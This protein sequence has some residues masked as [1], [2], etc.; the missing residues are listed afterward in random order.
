[1]LAALDI[2]D[3]DGRRPGR[4]ELLKCFRMLPHVVLNGDEV[5]RNKP[6]YFGIGV[7]HGTHLLAAAS[8]R[9]EEVDH[10]ELTLLLS[11]SATLFNRA[12]PLYVSSSHHEPPSRDASMQSSSPA[13]QIKFH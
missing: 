8:M 1:M 10:H 12:P 6:I 3:N 4:V 5:L 2:L 7:R 9:V 13:P 11:L